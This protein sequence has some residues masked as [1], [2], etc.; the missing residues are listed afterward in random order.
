VSYP[1]KDT[2]HVTEALKLLIDQFKGQPVIV[3][4]LTSW[5]NR[6]QELEDALFDVITKRILDDAAD[7]QL[8]S[9]GDLVGEEREGRGD[10][11]YREAIRLKIR[12][13][14]SK[15]KSEDIVQV[16]NQAT[17]GS[18]SYAE[19]FPASFWVFA[20]NVLSAKSLAQALHK[21]KAAGTGG[22]LV[23]TEWPHTEDLILD[24]VHGGVSGPRG[25]GSVYDSSILAKLTG[26]LEI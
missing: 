13:N 16:T 20:Y 24:S 5:T 23:F 10:S 17:G 14:R 12:V 2:A 25:P 9:I 11:D 26:A 15:G 8:D 19:Y 21:T 3:G 6:I 18:F 7:A 4:I 1:V 22:M